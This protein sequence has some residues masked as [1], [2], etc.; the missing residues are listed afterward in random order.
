MA[1]HSTSSRR[2]L[3]L[4]LV[5]AA[6]AAASATAVQP[7]SADIGPGPVVGRPSP[8]QGGGTL[9]CSRKDLDPAAYKAYCD[10]PPPVIDVDAVATAP[11][12][13]T[14]WIPAGGTPPAGY[15]P[16]PGY[17]RNSG[18]WQAPPPTELPPFEEEPAT[19]R[20][21][22]REKIQHLLDAQA[23]C[24]AGDEAE[25]EVVRTN[26]MPVIKG[27]STGSGGGFIQM[28][29]TR[30]DGTVDT[31]APDPA[32]AQC[33]ADRAARESANNKNG[34]DPRDFT[35]AKP[36]DNGPDQANVAADNVNGVD[37]ADFAGDNGVDPGLAQF[38]RDNGI[39]PGVIAD[40]FD[41]NGG[42]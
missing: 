10:S 13:R 24:D 41:D 19:R 34:I 37:P 23:A 16:A 11:K 26:K 17:P 14:V 33:K 15:V 25:C 22:V 5:G 7:A 1:F 27:T 12:R 2:L 18:F 28:F 9:D 31:C 4:V 42:S 29:P 3:A 35:P 40:F 20:D 36:A 6:A 8:S 39:D 30:P 38:A 32:S 21:P